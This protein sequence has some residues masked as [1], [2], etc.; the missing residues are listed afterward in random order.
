MRWVA[1][2]LAVV[3][4]VVLAACASKPACP[5]APTPATP[6]PPFLWKVQ[7]K[8]G[9]VWLYGTIHSAGIDAVPSVALDALAASKRV[10]TE[11]GNEQPDE[12]LFRTY[13]W[14]RHGQGLEYQ[15]P[16]SEWDELREALRGKVKEH[17]L[18]RAQPWWAM[19]QLTRAAGPTGKS[20]DDLLVKRAEERDLPVDALETWDA[21]LKVMSKAVTLADLRETIHARK[22][23]H[24]GHARLHASYEA[25]NTEAM[26]ALLVRPSHAE[27]MLYVRNRAWLP[28]LEKYLAADGAFVAVGLGHLL[29]E[30]GLPALLA[31][32]GYVVTRAM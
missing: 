17:D 25:G 12:E 1:V 30:Q 3:F 18:R 28:A 29:G 16:E 8:P 21:Q 32:A 22:L 6:G 14:N 15:L 31:K 2:V 23:L 24:C 20:M 26:T 10:A 11:L 27:K 9:V 4:V 5:V 19:S 7:G 13:A